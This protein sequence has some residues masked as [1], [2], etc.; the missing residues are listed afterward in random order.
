[1]LVEILPGA[2][3]KRE[4]IL[5]EQCQRGRELSDDRRMVADRGAV[6]AVVRRIRLVRAAIAPSTLQAIDECAWLVSQGEK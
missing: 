3:T 5:A 4:A 1:V 6:T 2:K